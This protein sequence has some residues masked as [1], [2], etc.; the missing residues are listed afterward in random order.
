MIDL[1]QKLPLVE[2]FFSIQGEGYNVG[3]SALFI[4]FAGCNLDCVFADGS[5]CDTPWRG[6]KEHPT[7]EEI[8]AW[9]RSY[10]TER[11]FWEQDLSIAP[12]S[13]SPFN[14]VMV[15][16]TG[17]EPTLALG[18]DDLVKGLSELPVFVAVETNGT[19]WRETLPLCD[20][21]TVSP[22]DLPGIS[23]HKPKSPSEVNLSVLNMC[24]QE[25][26]YV[27]TGPDDLRDVPDDYFDSASKHFVSPALMSDGSGLEWQKGVPEFV[28]GAVKRCCEIIQ[29]R[30]F[31]RL[32]LQT[33]KW[34]CVR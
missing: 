17:G 24:P 32:S 29:E 25:F 10:T 8:L 1:T 5:I 16:L 15:V 14:Q 21:V 9:I 20:W 18:F 26:R 11:E 33:H 23:H 31:I 13:S 7:L 4:R 27:I 19:L 22:K 2:T 3:R 30:P 28:P 6:A 34:I 12:S